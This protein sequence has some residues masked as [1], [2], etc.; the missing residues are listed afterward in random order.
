MFAPSRSPVAIRM[1]SSSSLVLRWG[2]GSTLSQAP[3]S[4]VATERRRPRDKESAVESKILLNDLS[5]RA[6]SHTR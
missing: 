6:S 5:T 4:F 2:D 3:D 1:E